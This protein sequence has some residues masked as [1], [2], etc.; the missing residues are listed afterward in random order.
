MIRRGEGAVGS[1]YFSSFQKRNIFLRDQIEDSLMLNN[2]RACVRGCEMI[3]F[4]IDALGMR[5]IS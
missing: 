2:D 5:L 3:L 1:N 4:A